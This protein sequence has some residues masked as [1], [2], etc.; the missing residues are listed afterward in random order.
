MLEVYERAAKDAAADGEERERHSV[1]ALKA[2]R[3]AHFD[4]PRPLPLALSQSTASR[5]TPT[6][7]LTFHRMADRAALLADVKA[8]KEDLKLAR[9]RWADELKDNAAQLAALRD[10]LLQLQ[11]QKAFNRALANNVQLPP[12]TPEST[13][14]YLEDKKSGAAVGKPD[15]R[16]EVV[17]GT[18]EGLTKALDRSQGAEASV[19]DAANKALQSYATEAPRTGVAPEVL[20]AAMVLSASDP[21]LRPESREYADSTGTD[22]DLQA[23][24][25][26][27]R[28]ASCAAD[29]EQAA[30]GQLHNTA[31]K[32][33]GNENERL[34]DAVNTAKKDLQRMSSG[35]DADRNQSRDAEAKAAK[36]LLTALKLVG[37]DGTQAERDLDSRA[38]S[39]EQ[40]KAQL[41]RDLDDL[42]AQLE[43]E[44]KRAQHQQ[45][46]ADRLLKEER[47]ALRAEVDNLK[48]KN[49]RLESEL[50]AARADSDAERDRLVKE[51]RDLKRKLADAENDMESLRADLAK[52]LAD[53]KR[54]KQKI[55]ADD[56]E[57]QLSR[58]QSRLRDAEAKNRNLDAEVED[59]KE[60]VRLLNS[61]PKPTID[62]GAVKDLE[63]QLGEARQALYDAESTVSF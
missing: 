35:L 37:E 50:A 2:E 19:L 56:L 44:R 32:Y 9:K 38:H 28:G 6:E 40:D 13:R 43:A 17:E 12:R 39:L 47:D 18:I 26:A 30:L 23:Q 8:K 5:R 59:L 3:Y 49:G 29:A 45:D 42:R 27:L 46:D 22:G 10:E 52:A 53:L 14:A 24:V 15:E 63:R 31:K 33:M 48:A 4:S 16:S 51:N 36:D 55:D 7:E 34:S 41:E 60:Q 25:T 21:S 57:G 62:D 54:L 61:R 20:G 1:D 11:A 58:A